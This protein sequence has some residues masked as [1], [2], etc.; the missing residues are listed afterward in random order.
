M[1]RRVREAI[2]D[3]IPEQIHRAVTKPGHQPN[4]VLGRTLANPR[5]GR[6]RAGNTGTSMFEQVSPFWGRC[7]WLSVRYAV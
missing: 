3:R 2:R 1:A 7:P 4:P 5:H 6:M